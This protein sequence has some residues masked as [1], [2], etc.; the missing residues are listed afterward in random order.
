MSHQYSFRKARV[1]TCQ[2]CDQHEKKIR[3]LERT[4]ANLTS[5]PS[6][7]KTESEL[8]QVKMKLDQHLKESEIRYGAMD[9]DIN[10]LAKSK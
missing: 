10:V 1:D 8:H 4:I 3:D 7:K 2:T 6:K 5:A 9:F